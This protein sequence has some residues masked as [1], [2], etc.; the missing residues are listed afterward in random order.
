M[1]KAAGRWHLVHPLSTRGSPPLNEI[2]QSEPEAVV[3]LRTRNE[4]N[5]KKAAGQRLGGF[6]RKLSL[7]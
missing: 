1:H 4:L 6:R 7:A 2:A 5:V 3:L